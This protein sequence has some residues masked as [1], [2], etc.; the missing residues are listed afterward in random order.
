MDVDRAI[1]PAVCTQSDKYQLLSLCLP[2]I[3]STMEDIFHSTTDT[4]LKIILWL[5]DINTLKSFVEHR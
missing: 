5:L 4:A 3:S 1:K 2:V